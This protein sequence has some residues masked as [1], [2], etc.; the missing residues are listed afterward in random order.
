MESLNKLVLSISSNPWVILLTIIFGA[1]GVIG[2][3]I[4]IKGLRYMKPRYSIRSNN[5]IQNFA[6]KLT[7]L[8]ILY[9][10]EKISNVTVSKLI[11][12]ND[13]NKTILDTDIASSDPF[14]VEGIE[15]VKI[16]E[17]EKIFEK[18]K[19][20]KFEVEVLE[21]GKKLAIN[22]EYVDKNEGIIIQIVH[23]GKTSQDIKVGGTIKGVGKIC[24]C[25]ASSPLNA[26][27]IM[28]FF[29]KVLK[30]VVIERDKKRKS[31]VIVIL[32]LVLFVFSISSTTRVDVLIE[33]KVA[34][35]LTAIMAVIYLIIGLSIA[36]RRIPKGFD[37]F[38]EIL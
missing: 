25:E 9:D 19:T 15:G 24:K 26:N 4:T 6:A 27:P 3:I 1:I 5:L 7:K 35:I 31:W 33:N 10:D 37:S 29:N 11:F 22:F 20:N 38:E 14:V 28:R 30:K 12:W 36:K 2:V 17:V 34:G 21:D 18:N 13:G 23:T 16:L 8:N 32:S